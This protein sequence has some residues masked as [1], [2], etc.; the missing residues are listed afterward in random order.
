MA[1]IV[2]SDYH[3]VEVL[4]EEAVKILKELKILIAGVGGLGSFV[5]LELAHLG[6]RH[7]IIVDNDKV[8]HTNLNRQV[9]YT[10][11]DV[12][13][14]KVVVAAERLR[15]IFPDLTVEAFNTR[16]DRA[17]APYMVS[18]AD[19]VIDCTDNF[20]TKKLL[21]RVCYAQ[22]RAFITGGV[23]TWEGWVA[24]FPFFKREEEEVPCLECLFPGDVETMQEAGATGQPTLVTVVATVASVQVN[25][26][27]K[28]VAG[29]NAG[30]NLEGKTL[31]IDLKNYQCTAV[32]I[33]K[34][35]KC[36]VCSRP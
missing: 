32:K 13:R 8:S 24:S 35:P 28:L 5:A 10:V 7:L 14:S 3:N 12:G 31:L 2:D 20:E 36:P 30:E 16:V 26:V 33:T 1:R 21:N 23:G 6:A 29:R 4:G 27:A 11:S 15:K 22:K 19:V 9:L 25:E 18:R 17:S 34:N